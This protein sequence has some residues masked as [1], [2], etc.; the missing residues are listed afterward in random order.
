VHYLDNTVVDN[1][2]VLCNHEEWFHL[3]CSTWDNDGLW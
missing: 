1:I 3:F 2:D